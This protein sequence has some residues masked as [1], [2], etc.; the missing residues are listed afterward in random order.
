MQFE[1]KGVMPAVT[2]KFTDNDEL[3]LNLFEVNLNAQID[4]GVHGIV[5]GGTL[6]ELLAPPG[7]NF[8]LKFMGSGY[9]KDILEA[10]GPVLIERGFES[11]PSK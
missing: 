11:L 9:F 1:W 10:P 3:D 4:A 2:T 6:G 5:L 7:S 8:S